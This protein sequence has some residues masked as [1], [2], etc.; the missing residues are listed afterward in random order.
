[1][2]NLL[3]EANKICKHYFKNFKYH[4]IPRDILDYNKVKMIKAKNH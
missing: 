4:A 3:K 2:K 1:M